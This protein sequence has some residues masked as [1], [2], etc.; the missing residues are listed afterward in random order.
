MQKELKQKI[1]KKP[2]KLSPNRLQKSDQKNCLNQGTETAGDFKK[3]C[4]AGAIHVYST[5]GETKSTFVERTIRSLKKSYTDIWRHMA[6]N[7]FT[8][9]LNLSRY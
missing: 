7:I 5:M 3:F 1:Q 6:T 4:A 8:I 9:C 2:L